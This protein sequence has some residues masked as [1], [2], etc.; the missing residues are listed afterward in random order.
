MRRFSYFCFAAWV[1]L[2]ASAAWAQGTQD[3]YTISVDENG[4]GSY[5]EYSPPVI[6]PQYAIGSGGLPSS[7]LPDG[8]IS[9]VLPYTVTA[10]AEGQYKWLG[11]YDSDGQTKSD[12]VS[13]TNI[14]GG[15]TGIM[16][17]FSN[18]TDGDLADVTPA[19]WATIVGNWDGYTTVEDANNV[20]FY[21]TY[22]DTYGVPG[23]P[24][25]HPTVEANYYVTSGPVPEPTSLAL[26][27][28]FAGMGLVG[29]VWR[30]RKLA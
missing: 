8:G 11:I 1:L 22:G 14:N 23:D 12:L 24:Y 25:P 21:S 26:L 19:Y 3:L 7:T 16:N 18:D 27:G 9:Y 5:V 30:R 10:T 20:A 29:F 15:Q 13:F 6:A 4:N 28:V 2:Q 17:L